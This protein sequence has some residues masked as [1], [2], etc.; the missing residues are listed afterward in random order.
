[1]CHAWK[2]RSA[3]PGDYAALER[4][5]AICS[6]DTVVNCHR[7]VMIALTPLAQ[8]N[9]A[10][11][12]VAAVSE[13]MSCVAKH[14]STVGL[15]RLALNLF[16]PEAVSA[17]IERFRWD[18]ASNAFPHSQDPGSVTT[19]AS[20]LLDTVQTV[21]RKLQAMAQMEQCTFLAFQRVMDHVVFIS[22]TSFV[23][24]VSRIKKLSDGGK[25]QLLNDALVITKS[26]KSSHPT[27][28]MK[29][30]DYALKFARA[31][32]APFAEAA[33]FVNANHQLYSAKQLVSLG[34]REGFMKKR[35]V[36]QLLSR[37][38]HEDRLPLHLMDP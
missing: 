23:D 6:L 9:D 8:Q 2:V 12:A 28:S 14:C 38:Q 27:T 16:P 30:L 33:E 21:H 10:A 17:P 24:G 34:D 19:A 11:E 7:L 15:R 5:T 13:A 25:N 3:V 26:L 4:S 20:G 18:A 35:E 32:V 37:L 22:L 1:M 36:E 29:L 31:V